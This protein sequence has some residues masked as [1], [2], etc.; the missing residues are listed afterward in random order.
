MTAVA[1]DEI[2]WIEE[3]PRGSGIFSLQGP[4]LDLVETGMI[5][6]RQPED[7]TLELSFRQRLQRSGWLAKLAARELCNGFLCVLA[8]LGVWG[9][10]LGRRGK[11][12]AG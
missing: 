7:R 10:I 5:I 1:N 4:W 12:G 6:V 9:K 3:Y 2:Q 8:G 11:Q